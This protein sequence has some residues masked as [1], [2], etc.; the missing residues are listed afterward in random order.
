MSYHDRLPFGAKTVVV[1]GKGTYAFKPVGNCSHATGFN[2]YFHPE[3]MPARSPGQGRMRV[4]ITDDLRWDVEYQATYNLSPD[5]VKAAAEPAREWLVADQSALLHA[6]NGTAVMEH[7]S[8]VGRRQDLDQCHK[9]RQAWLARDQ[10][11]AQGGSEPSV[12][13]PEKVEAAWLDLVAYDESVAD[14]KRGLEAVISALKERTK[15]RAGAKPTTDEVMDQ[16]REAAF[17]SAGAAPGP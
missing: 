12:M 17:P 2:V 14:R 4:V 1:P 8:I 3:G 15:R 13:T 16:A 9:G 5:V 6:I 10:A 7:G 11:R